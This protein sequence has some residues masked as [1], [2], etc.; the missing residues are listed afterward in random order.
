M[1]GQLQRSASMDVSKARE[2]AVG[3]VCSKY[4]YHRRWDATLASMPSRSLKPCP[5]TLR[6]EPHYG[7]TRGEQVPA[8]GRSAPPA[9]LQAS[10]PTPADHLR[11][12]HPALRNPSVE[13]RT[14]SPQA[15]MPIA[16]LAVC[17][18]STTG[19]TYTSQHMLSR[20][21]VQRAPHRQVRAKCAPSAQRKH[22]PCVFCPSFQACASR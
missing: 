7:S 18:A 15:D 14:R 2:T 9:T 3:S 1:L 13:Q 19:A 12:T 17:K 4:P 8:Q 16:A 20:S 21:S 5:A 6:L 11:D 10:S 22:R